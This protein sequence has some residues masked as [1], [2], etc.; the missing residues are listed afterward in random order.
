MTEYDYLDRTGPIE[1]LTF[2]QAKATDRKLRLFASA[3]C[4]HVWDRLSSTDKLIVPLVEQW[5]D[6]HFDLEEMRRRLDVQDPQ[7]LAV[8]WDYNEDLYAL[9]R[10]LRGDHSERLKDYAEAFREVRLS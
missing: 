6:G 10:Q 5:A 2:M 3:C 4:R 9:R 7:F 1:F 8:P